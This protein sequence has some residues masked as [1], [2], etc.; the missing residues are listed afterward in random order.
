MDSILDGIGMIFAIALAIGILYGIFWLIS[1]MH[2][3]LAKTTNKRVVV[4]RY[5]SITGMYSPGD[6]DRMTKDMKEAPAALFNK[7]KAITGKT[8]N[9]FK[10]MKIEGVI[11]DTTKDKIEKLKSIQELKASNIITP[12]EFQVLKDEILNKQ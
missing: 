1:Y 9:A 8:M 12:E 6:F 4:K 7:L 10:R 2:A 3:F 11:N 5:G